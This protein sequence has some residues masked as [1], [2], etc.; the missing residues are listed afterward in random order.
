MATPVHYNSSP[1]ARNQPFGRTT[2]LEVRFAYTSPNQKTTVVVLSNAMPSAAEMDPQ[3]IARISA[4][5]FLAD[6]IAKLPPRQIDK[7]I[8]P[9][10]YTDYV[11]RYDYVSLVRK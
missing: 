9:K 8:D 3:L 1:T 7:S 11:G 4:E 2:R 10:T 6:E 5:K